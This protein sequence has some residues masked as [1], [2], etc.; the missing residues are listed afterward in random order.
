[1]K[2]NVEP[3]LLHVSTHKRIRV[4]PIFFS[5]RE[6]TNETT[7]MITLPSKDI[8]IL[9]SMILLELHIV[10]SEDSNPKDFIFSHFE[11]KDDDFHEERQK[12]RATPSNEGGSSTTPSRCHNRRSN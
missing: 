8:I 6:L 10:S 5:R 3:S 2:P 12:N 11:C 1:M 4:Y 7:V 9:I